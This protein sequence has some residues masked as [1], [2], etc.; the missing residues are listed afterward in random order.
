M[1]QMQ[2]RQAQPPPTPPPTQQ[3]QTEQQGALLQVRRRASQP[4]L[5][6]AY[7][8]MAKRVHPDKTRDDLGFQI[9]AKFDASG[10]VIW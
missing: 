7:R 6:S 5:R 1:Q 2:A 10:R 9:L 8:Q 4:Q 3:Q